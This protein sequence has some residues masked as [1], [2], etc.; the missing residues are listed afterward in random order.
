MILVTAN[1][2]L[3]LSVLSYMFNQNR[4]FRL[5]QLINYL[6]SRPPKTVRSIEQ[7][8]NT[9]ERTVY[10][11]IDLLR[12]LGFT[13]E[14]DNNNKLSIPKI[15]ESESIPFSQQETD[16]LKR[17]LH[18]SGKQNKLAQSI[19][20]K[21][22]TT[23]ELEAGAESIFKAHL[24]K[25]VEEI[26]EAIIEG[27]QLK[28]KGYHSVNSQTTSDRIVEPICFTD[29]YTSLA[30]YEIKSKENKYFNIERM[31]AVQILK[32]AVQHESKHEF[33]KPDIF[34][35]QGK[36]LDKEIELK[37][38]MRAA[39]LLKEEYPMSAALLKEIPGSKQFH[40]KAKVQSFKAPGRFVLGFTPEVE[41]LGSKAFESYIKKLIQKPA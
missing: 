26:A 37:L 31:T 11:Y 23:N 40:F 20:Q 10:R 18:S 21:I 8:L 27:K 2:C 15:A 24:A 35:F 25:L 32:T 29:N 9:S 4:L 38:S 41:V 5:F 3:Y 39:L 19:L 28:I 6:K 7:F 12:D 17:L 14:K 13:V 16:Y 30:A 36:T 34:G 33:Y 22:Q 1:N